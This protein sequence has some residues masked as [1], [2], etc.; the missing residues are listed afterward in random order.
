MNKKNFFSGKYKELYEMSLNY[1]K[2]LEFKESFYLDADDWADLADW[3]A[4]RKKGE[5]AYK[6]AEEGLHQHP[7]HTGLLVQ[8]AYLYL[9]EHQ[10][11]EAQRIIDSIEDNQ[12]AEVIILKASLLMEQGENSLAENLLENITIPMEM[13]DFVEIIYFYIEYEMAQ[14]AWPWLDKLKEC[15]NE[16]AYTVVSADF[17]YAMHQYDK[18]IEKYNLL[19]DKEPYSARFWYGLSR[20]YLSKNEL[21]KAIEAADFANVGDEEFG[22]AYFVKA[23]AYT[24][25]N[26]TKKAQYN[27]IM[28]T[29]YDAITEDIYLYYEAMVSMEQ[30]YWRMAY[31]SLREILTLE[32]PITTPTKTIYSQIAICLNNMGEDK[33]AMEYCGLAEELDPDNIT[34]YFTEAEIYLAQDKEELCMKALTKATDLDS[35]ASTWIKIAQLYSKYYKIDLAQMAFE[36]AEQIDPS[37]PG[38]L[39]HMTLMYLVLQNKEKFLEYNAKCDKP[40]SMAQILQVQQWFESNGT[41]ED[42]DKI[43]DIISS[44]Q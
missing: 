39:E 25:L 14:K 12:Q 21:D 1:E 6:A 13:N 15:G 27:Y 29:K 17:Y 24:Q 3:Y 43:K 11:E 2:A 26:N 44:L 18:A 31:E 19:L 32:G 28:A 41:A 22:D 20:C 34:N 4:D 37:T 23:M 16:Y 30:Q 38:L 35:T 9:Y 10:P 7:G 33:Q 42:A 5:L 36:R 40:L 8:Q